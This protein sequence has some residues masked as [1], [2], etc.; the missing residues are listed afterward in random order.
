MIDITYKRLSVG[1]YPAQGSIRD[2]ETVRWM[3]VR[4][5]AFA[6][7]SAKHF[8]KRTKAERER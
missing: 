7:M 5:A 2:P 4:S 3:E 6:H 1:E 8:A